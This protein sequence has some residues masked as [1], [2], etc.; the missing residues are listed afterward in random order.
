MAL[1][2]MSRGVSPYVDTTPTKG[3]LWRIWSRGSMVEEADDEV[4][5]RPNRGEGRRSAWWKICEERLVDLDG[6]FCLKMEVLSLD[7]LLE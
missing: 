7:Q 2:N 5:A 3:T 6:L 4:A 1:R